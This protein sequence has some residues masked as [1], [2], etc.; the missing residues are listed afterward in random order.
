MAITGDRYVGSFAGHTIELVR[1]NWVKTLAL[2][3]D[4]R[5]V[6]RA[7]RVWPRDITLEG[8]LQH[9]GTTHTVVARSL[10]RSFFWA[11]DAI[12]VDGQPLSVTKTK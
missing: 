12:E 2:L 10:V 8:T 9:D 6:A 3:I 7:S 4:G 11:D 5:E 1:D